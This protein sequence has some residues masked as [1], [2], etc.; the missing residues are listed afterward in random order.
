V[1]V[2]VVSVCVV[3]C[4]SQKKLSLKFLFIKII[5]HCIPVP[6]GNKI[7]NHK[8]YHGSSTIC[9]V[10]VPLCIDISYF[11]LFIVH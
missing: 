1:C 2:R 5:L 3:P 11:L 4:E 10:T 6:Y 8:L 9:K 7:F